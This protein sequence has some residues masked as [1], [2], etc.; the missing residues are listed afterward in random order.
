MYDE[1]AKDVLDDYVKRH[2]AARA[3]V[4]SDPLF[5]AQMELLRRTID[6]LLPALRR[7]GLDPVAARR[8][9]N[10]IVYGVPEPDAAV[11]RM[12]ERDA[13]L[14]EAMIQPAVLHVPA[15][16]AKSFNFG[17]RPQAGDILTSVD[18]EPPVGTLVR[19]DCGTRW[20]NV[21]DYWVPMDAKGD[22]WEPESWAKIAGNYGPVTVLAG[23]AGR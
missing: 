14:A 2:P 1:Q 3:A 6:L 23:R 21:G 5:T 4:E 22:G 12:A 9:I 11:L 20:G 19:D 7:E 13:Q 8:V 17:R 16:L 10:T 18:P 15:E